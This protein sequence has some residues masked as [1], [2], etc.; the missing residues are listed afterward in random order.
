MFKKILGVYVIAIIL[1]HSAIA[2]EMIDSDEIG[3]SLMA[4]TDNKF[5]PDSSNLDDNA[6]VGSSHLISS[7][8]SEWKKALEIRNAEEKKRLNE[9]LDKR[10]QLKNELETK[11]HKILENK[12]ELVASTTQNSSSKPNRTIFGKITDELKKG[13]DERNRLSES[14][15]EQ[16]DQIIKQID[17]LA[18]KIHTVREM[19]ELMNK[20]SERSAQA[21]IELQEEVKKFNIALDEYEKKRSNVLESLPEVLENHVDALEQATNTVA[22]A[23]DFLVNKTNQINQLERKEENQELINIVDSI[24]ER[25]EKFEEKSDGNQEVK[26]I[27]FL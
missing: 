9:E 26:D 1:S 16:A 27:G 22:Q 20:S 21:S 6:A 11:N 10:D 5:H 8:K 7:P 23:T 25:E 4:S 12:N 19:K 24:N 15:N 14:I 3:K 2:F 18:P 17:V 13:E